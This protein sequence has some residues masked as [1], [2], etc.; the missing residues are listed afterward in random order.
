M[1]AVPERGRH[2]RAGHSLTGLKRGEALCYIRTEAKTRK[3][4]AWKQ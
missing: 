3:I 2:P 4:V 1:A